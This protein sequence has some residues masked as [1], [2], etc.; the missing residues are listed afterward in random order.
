ME[1]PLNNNHLR[2]IAEYLSRLPRNARAAYQRVY[3]CKETTAGVEAV[4]LMADPDIQD[5]I[6]RRE[7]QLL[8][9]LELTAADV[10]KEIFLVATA[11]PRELS[12]HYRG[13]CR[14]CWGIDFKYQRRP[15][16]YNRDFET[17]KK[18]HADDPYGVNFDIL[19]GVGFTTR[20]APNSD[21]PECDGNG[22]S[23]EIFKDTRSLSPGAARLF[24][25]VERTRD[26]LKIKVRNREKALD[27]AAQHVGISRKSVELTGKGGGPIRTEGNALVS[28]AGV[29]PQTAAAMYQTLVGGS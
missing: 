21:C 27:L 3:D 24:D 6:A 13:A 7:K 4:R 1:R 28:L 8:E 9:G 22:E 2:F 11:D 23:Y 29:D 18:A 25:G 10:L 26:G 19:G 17:Y 12:E 20:K 14:N 15:S 5:E 16:E